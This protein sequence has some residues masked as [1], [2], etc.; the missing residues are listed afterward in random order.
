MHGIS[1]LCNVVYLSFSVRM[2][3]D[4]KNSNKGELTVN[5]PSY[6]LIV[7]AVNGDKV[8]LDLII[9]HYQSMIEKESKGDPVIRKQITDALREAILHYDLENPAAIDEYLQSK[10][11]SRD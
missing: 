8:A 10:Y 5:K 9:M 3:Y 4:D 7:A 11:P 2:C 6:D 1:L